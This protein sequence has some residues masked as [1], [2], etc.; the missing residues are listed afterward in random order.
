MQQ[1]TTWPAIAFWGDCHCLTGVQDVTL[2]LCGPRRVWS[3]SG[4]QHPYLK[5][6]GSE[7]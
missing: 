1:E 7:L 2:L 3:L 6:K 4:L 5:K